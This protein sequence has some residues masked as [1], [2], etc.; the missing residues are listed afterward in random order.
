ML[1]RVPGWGGEWGRWLD[2]LRHSCRTARD[3]RLLPVSI[4]VGDGSGAEGVTPVAAGARS[5]KKQSPARA[6]PAIG[7]EHRPQP[8]P[9]LPNSPWTETRF[10]IP[11]STV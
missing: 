3:R 11:K 8:G 4:I 2:S 10:S 6:T 9:D 7:Q 1:K 5:H